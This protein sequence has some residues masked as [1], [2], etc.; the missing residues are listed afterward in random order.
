MSPLSLIL[1]IDGSFTKTEADKQKA[2]QDYLEKKFADHISDLSMVESAKVTLTMPKDDGTILSTDTKYIAFENALDDEGV[3][4]TEAQY[5][6][7]MSELLTKDMITITDGV[8]NESNID[9][10]V[11]IVTESLKGL[12]YAHAKKNA[13]RIG[14]E[15]SYD[16]PYSG[17]IGV[18]DNDLFRFFIEKVDDSAPSKTVEVD[19]KFEPNKDFKG[20]AEI[21]GTY[22][23][24]VTVT[25]SKEF[26]ASIS[27]IDENENYVDVTNLDDIGTLTFMVK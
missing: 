2:Y 6:S 8:N 26:T 25:K 11:N 5:Q 19:L 17:T 12:Y 18:N 16:N 7:A 13:M 10:K 3:K 15:I 24:K 9:L 27:F 14:R 1:I 4:L 22:P 23:Q 21:D 20:I